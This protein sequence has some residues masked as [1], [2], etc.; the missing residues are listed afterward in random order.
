MSKLVGSVPVPETSGRP[1]KA[2]PS[3]ETYQVWG[4]GKTD[5]GTPLG[6]V[7]SSLA[8]MLVAPADPSVAPPLVQVSGSKC[9]R[10][11]ISA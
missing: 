6:S 8:K 5:P 2:P 10:T 4:L 11:V 3:A 1:A 7:G 9:E